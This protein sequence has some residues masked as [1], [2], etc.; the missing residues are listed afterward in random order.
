VIL[1][2]KSGFPD[3]NHRFETG[4]LNMP[5]HPFERLSYDKD[6]D[7][8]LSYLY[9]LQKFG[10]KF[11][12]S[13]TQKLLDKFD[14]PQGS[15]ALIHVGGSN[16]KGS[17][18]AMLDSVY[19]QAGYRVGLFT[20]PHLVDFRERFRINGQMISKEETLSLVHEI[21]AKCDPEEPPTFFEFVTAMALIYFH[22]EKV[23]L[24]I[25]E[26]GLGGRLDATNIIQPL[27]AVITGIS[28]EHQEYLGNTL[29]RIAS[30]K[31][32]IIKEGVPLITGVTQKK[33]QERLQTVCREKNAPMLLAGRDFR[34]RKTGTGAFTFYCSEFGV[35]S[36]ERNKKG[37]TTRKSGTPNS[38]L[39]TPNLKIALLGDHQIKN[40]GLALS[41][42]ETL[43]DQFPAGE[44]EIRQGLG[45]VTWPGRLEVLS[46]DPLIVLDGAHN[47][48]AMSALARTLPRALTYK[49]LHLVVGMMKDKDIE[50]TLK[51]ILPLA[52][53]VYLTRAEYDRSAEPDALVPF[54]K[55]MNRSFHICPTIPEA[56]LKARESAGPGD[57]ILITGSLFVVGEA[58]G[59]WELSGWRP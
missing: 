1:N 9:G 31:A 23:D 25:M 17:V 32:G 26:V 11:G 3:E 8:A 47:P 59:R 7:Q 45:L 48:G 46:R 57:L 58:R 53:N 41:V 36:S 43:K 30:E 50:K 15:L 55:K 49:R 51:H 37:R 28:L 27:A 13:S 6:Y 12:L 16:G 39:R 2:R 29:T 14:N 54:V 4:R 35:R 22:R 19:R 18:A 42:I 24:A 56:V 34:T 20:S 21:K 44:G 40:A 10:I 38:K 33:V 5:G 52:D